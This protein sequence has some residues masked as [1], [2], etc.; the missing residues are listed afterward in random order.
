LGAI[1]GDV[2]DVLV[3]PLWME[4]I[5]VIRKEM[6]GFEDNEVFQTTSRK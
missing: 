1:P 6:E 2:W 5:E 4:W 3:G